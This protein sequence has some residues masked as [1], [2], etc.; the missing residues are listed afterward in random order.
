MNKYTILFSLSFTIFTIKP[1]INGL[2]CGFKYINENTIIFHEM[3]CR[4]GILVSD[5][6]EKKTNTRTLRKSIYG[7]WGG[8]AFNVPVYQKKYV[9]KNSGKNAISPITKYEIYSIWSVYPYKS[10]DDNTTY[11]FLDSNF[12]ILLESSSLSKPSHGFI[13]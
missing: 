8:F 5:F 2:G 9:V 11:T 3:R 12:G 4:S 6:F 1:F 13:D 10:A 7:Y